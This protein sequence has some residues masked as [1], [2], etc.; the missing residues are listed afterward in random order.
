MFLTFR[1]VLTFAGGAPCRPTTATVRTPDPFIPFPDSLPDPRK[2]PGPRSRVV[3]V[4]EDRLLHHPTQPGHGEDAA[5][6]PLD[7]RTLGPPRRQASVLVLCRA[8]PRQTRSDTSTLLTRTLT[9]A[10]THATQAS[11]AVPS[12]ARSTSTHS[13]KSSSSTGSKRPNASGTPNLECGRARAARPCANRRT[14]SRICPNDR[15]WRGTPREGPGV[16]SR[17]RIRW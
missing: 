16:E 3:P 15:A 14:G 6:L 5:R 11:T 8:C 9:H 10:P 17:S 12:A 7:P 2:I 1:F 13:R 4:V